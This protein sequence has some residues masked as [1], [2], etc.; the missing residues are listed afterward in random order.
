[1][2]GLENAALLA[3]LDDEIEEYREIVQTQMGGPKVPLA[4]H[5]ETT[6]QGNYHLK[7]WVDGEVAVDV[8][9]HDRAGVYQ[10]AIGVFRSWAEDQQAWI[11]DALEK[12]RG[13][14]G[15]PFPL[16]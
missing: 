13:S 7:L 8:T 1:M 10:K 4:M 9:S 6:R 11:A 2:M 12:S 15:G 5:V 14:R 16:I 3:A